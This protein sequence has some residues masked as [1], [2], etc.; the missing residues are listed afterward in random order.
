MGFADKI[1]NIM[2]KYFLNFDIDDKLNIQQK[3]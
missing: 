1:Y 2:N 3:E